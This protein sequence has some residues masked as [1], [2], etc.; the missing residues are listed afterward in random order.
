MEE[1]VNLQ[2]TID[3][4]IEERI[5]ESY[6][7]V[8]NNQRYKKLLINYNDLFNK[9]KINVVNKKIIDDYR[10]SEIDFYMVQLKEAYRLGFYDSTKIFI[11][12]N[13]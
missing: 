13:R 11:N 2:I 12:T 6:K 4:F 9:V 5:Q 3:E 8:I 7:N 1:D 10:I